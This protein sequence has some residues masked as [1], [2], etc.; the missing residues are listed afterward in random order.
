MIKICIISAGE[1]KI[2]ERFIESLNFIKE[3]FHCYILRNTPTQVDV[4][5][6]GN[7]TMKTVPNH[8]Y[9][10]AGRIQ[11]LKLRV[12]SVEMSNPQ[13]GD[14]VMLGDDDMIFE[15]GVGLLPAIDLLENKGIDF[16]VGRDVPAPLFWNS[17]LSTGIYHGHLFK[18][19][20][21]VWEKIKEFQEFYGG[22]EDGI[23]AALHYKYAGGMCLQINLPKVVHVGYNSF[24]YTQH[25]EDRK[26]I[27]WLLNYH[28]EFTM[29]VYDQEIFRKFNAIK[30]ELT[31]PTPKL[32]VV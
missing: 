18:Y 8:N 28:P 23:I 30:N 25:R 11:L 2:L 15:N 4:S 16:I 20:K 14:I 3:E 26:S 1:D 9:R 7:I 17:C 19:K 10:E 24:A 6:N 12:E 32:F 22:G 31:A 13:E 21:N 5:G 27:A 29:N